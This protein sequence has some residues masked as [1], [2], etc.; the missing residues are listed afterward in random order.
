MEISPLSEAVR[1]YLRRC[2]VT[3]TGVA[4][5]IGVSRPMLSSRLSRQNPL[6]LH[7]AKDIELTG[8]IAAY[9]GVSPDDIIG[10]AQELDQANQRVPNVLLI[11]MLLDVL[12]DNNTPAERK[13]QA[14]DIIKSMLGVGN[15]QISA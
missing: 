8:R 6:S 4:D 14:K 7:S 5:G 10:L 2:K 9:I 1:Q 3:V 13:A 15:E 11:D 12:A